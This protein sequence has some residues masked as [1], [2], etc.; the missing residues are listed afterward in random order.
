MSGAGGV[1]FADKDRPTDRSTDRA[2][3]LPLPIRARAR[4]GRGGSLS[5]SLP[6]KRKS[7]PSYYIGLEKKYRPG[8]SEAAK[9][10]RWKKRST[11]DEGTAATAGAAE[12]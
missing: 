1:R 11:A 6:P 5:P 2:K 9:I 3:I 10:G 12:S 4:I 8:K 7:K